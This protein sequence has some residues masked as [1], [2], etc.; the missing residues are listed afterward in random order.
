MGLRRIY[1][2][3]SDLSIKD[4]VLHY[5]KEL[6]VDL[7][8]LIFELKRDGRRFQFPADDTNIENFVIDRDTLYCSMIVDIVFVCAVSFYSIFIFQMHVFFIV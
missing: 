2:I 7:D 1:S 6:H 3:D 4:A 8:S 5:A